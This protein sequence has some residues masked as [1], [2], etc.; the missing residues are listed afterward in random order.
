MV[1]V[2]HISN[3][4]VQSVSEPGSHRVQLRKAD[5]RITLLRNAK[6]VRALCGAIQCWLDSYTSL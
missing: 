4:H 1:H 5:R 3:Y 2:D 6:L